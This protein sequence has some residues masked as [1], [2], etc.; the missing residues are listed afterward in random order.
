MIY[1]AEIPI[2]VKL[3]VKICRKLDD[4]PSDGKRILWSNYDNVTS[5]PRE[6]EEL[7]NLRPNAMREFLESL[8][9]WYFLEEL[10]LHIIILNEREA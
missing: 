6:R 8:G 5:S 7:L 9:E 10:D 3:K 2:T 1:D 4:L